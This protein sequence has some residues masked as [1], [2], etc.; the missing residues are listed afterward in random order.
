MKRT[1]SISIYLAGG[2]ARAA[3]QLGVLKAFI[4]DQH[5]SEN[6]SKNK[7][8]INFIHGIS[9]GAMSAAYLGL[10]WDRPLIAIEN[11]IQIWTGLNTK[12]VFHFRI[13]SVL[14]TLSLIYKLGRKK[15]YAEFLDKHNFF[16]LSKLKT[17]LHKV[18][19]PGNI[20]RHL[21]NKVYKGLILSCYDYGDKKTIHF[22]QAS[23]EAS[24]SES[25]VNV[26]ISV[27]H[28]IASSSIPLIFPPHA[29]ANKKYGDGSFKNENPLRPLIS[30]NEKKILVIGVGTYKSS[31]SSNINAENY[32]SKLV[33]EVEKSLNS[34]ILFEHEKIDGVEVL[35]IVPSIDPTKVFLQTF[36]NRKIPSFWG[37]IL[38]RIAKLSKQENHYFFEI[39]SYLTFDREYIENLIRLGESD[40]LKSTDRFKKF[41]DN[42]TYDSEAVKTA[43]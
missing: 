34:N 29:I 21:I 43:A 26:D 22:F 18:D 1:Q 8:K 23:V 36:E 4:Q 16:G 20:K 38:K 7:V 35:N 2:G 42:E 37:S 9:A 27:D 19:Q 11:L 24:V 30:L 13:S 6:I 41:V 31:V 15:D 3:Y 39:L 14:S 17:A 12:I 25:F 10:H 28:V 5:N 32:Y 40:Y 33:N